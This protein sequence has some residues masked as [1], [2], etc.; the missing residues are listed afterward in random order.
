MITSDLLTV[1]F[2]D[3]LVSTNLNLHKTNSSVVKADVIINHNKIKSSEYNENKTKKTNCTWL[4]QHISTHKVVGSWSGR[5][6]LNL[7]EFP[8]LDLGTSLNSVRFINFIAF[9]FYHQLGLC[10]NNLQLIFDGSVITSFSQSFWVLDTT[11]LFTRIRAFAY[12]HN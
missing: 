1:E 9:N 4:F 10:D 12:F 3:K 2:V 6:D 7:S 11:S 5:I 8:W